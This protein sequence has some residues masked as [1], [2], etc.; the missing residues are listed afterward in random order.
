LDARL[1]ELVGKSE[2]DE[3]Y[4]DISTTSRKASIRDR[5]IG[6][7][8]PPRYQCSIGTMVPI[9]PIPGRTKHKILAR[10]KQFQYQYLYNLVITILSQMMFEKDSTETTNT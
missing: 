3:L 4:L 2:P 5:Q 7:L 8:D 6:T 10:A 1:L 9:P